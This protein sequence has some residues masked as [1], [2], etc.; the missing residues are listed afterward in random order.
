MKA[1]TWLFLLAVGAFV[2]PAPVS[3]DTR[4]GL[5]INIGPGYRD[6]RGGA[7][8]YGYE[9]GLRD[10]SNEGYKDARRSRSFELWREGDYRR[11]NSGYHGWMGPRWEYAEGYRRGYE[12]GYRRSFA[13]ARGGYRDDYARERDRWD[14]RYRDDRYR[15][16]YDDRYRDD[17]YRDDR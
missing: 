5:G 16:R 14:D 3:A 15:D 10:G 9:R 4:I 1:R 7:A 6:Y 12:Q 8:S 2:A 17:R 11:A 13:S